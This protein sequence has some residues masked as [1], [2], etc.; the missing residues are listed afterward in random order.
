VSCR[1]RFKVHPTS[2]VGRPVLRAVELHHVHVSSMTLLHMD[3]RRAVRQFTHGRSGGGVG[4]LG[5]G[6]VYLL[7]KGGVSTP[8]NRRVH[9]AE[10]CL[11]IKICISF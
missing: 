10:A 2:P 3:I 1:T 11:L 6:G 5:E 8:Q 4:L 7:S 9:S